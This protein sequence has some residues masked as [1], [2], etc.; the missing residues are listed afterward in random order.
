MARLGYVYDNLM[1]H[2]QLKN[3]KLLERG[4]AIVEEAAQ[5]DR[6]LALQTLQSAGMRVP[7]ALV[8]LKAK[9]SR[10]EAIRRLK[11]SHGIVREALKR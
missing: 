6:K 5:V 2:V 10:T 4:I 9:V 3:H 7:V 1:V 11:K 8:M